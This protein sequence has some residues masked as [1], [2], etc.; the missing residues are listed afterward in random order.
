MEGRWAQ[1]SGFENMENIL[2]AV[3]LKDADMRSMILRMK[4]E[5]EL[6]RNGVGWTYNLITPQGTRSVDF[7]S[8]Q[9]V[10]YVSLIGKPVKAEMTIEGHHLIETHR[11]PENSANETRI[12]RDFNGDYMITGGAR[13]AS[14][15]SSNADIDLI[16]RRQPSLA[17]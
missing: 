16:N 12:V 3:G 13:Q 9:I 2:D 7:K 17:V 14:D 15:L 6:I 5:I 11:D 8:G 1:E 4:P 10:D